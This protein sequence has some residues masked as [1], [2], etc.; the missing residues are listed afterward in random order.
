MYT[1]PSAFQNCKSVYLEYKN[2]KIVQ[3]VVLC[4]LET[5]KQ[6]ERKQNSMWMKEGILETLFLIG[7]IFKNAK[8][9]CFHIKYKKNPQI[10]KKQKQKT[11]MGTNGI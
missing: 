4:L 5:D 1:P 10:I 3:D 11:Q 9:K 8:C 2:G 7:V 6:K